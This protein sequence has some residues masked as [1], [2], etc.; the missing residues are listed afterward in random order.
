MPVFKLCKLNSGSYACIGNTHGFV[1]HRPYIKTCRD[2]KQFDIRT[3]I[4]LSLNRI[5]L[6]YYTMTAGAVK[7]AVSIILQGKN[8]DFSWFTNLVGALNS[9]AFLPLL[10]SFWRIPP[11]RTFR[12]IAS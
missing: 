7:A 1:R 3:Y 10:C 2:W 6:G 12:G 8:F 4:R 9:M 5:L 11:R